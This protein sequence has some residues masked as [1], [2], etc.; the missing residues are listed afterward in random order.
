[1]KKQMM[2]LTAAA[3]LVLGMASAAHAAGATAQLNIS[4]A[5]TASECNVKLDGASAA[6]AGLSPVL[7]TDIS[8]KTKT[9]VISSVLTGGKTVMATL[10][11]CAALP[12]DASAY[13]VFNGTEAKGTNVSV[14]DLHAFSDS[15]TDV[16]YGYAILAKGVKGP[17]DF[18]NIEAVVQHG[19]GT[20]S[21]TSGAA[22][23][24]KLI[25][26]AHTGAGVTATEMN[27]F[28][29]ELTPGY[30]NVGDT[31]PKPSG[32]TSTITVSFVSSDI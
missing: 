29:V 27:E 16:G 7:T 25:D 12:T 19:N 4:G 10:D 31:D 14:N 17:T 21:K 13:L 28:E 23:T 9:P 18:N 20:F 1:M 26:T 22:N 11:G 5:V 30:V 15:P 6:P 8:G 2:K 32:T 24:Y 3:A